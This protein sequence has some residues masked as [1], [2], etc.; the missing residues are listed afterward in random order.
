MGSI[1]FT[2]AASKRVDIDGRVELPGMIGN[3]P[4]SKR[5]T[6]ER[7]RDIVMRLWNILEHSDLQA[8][9]LRSELLS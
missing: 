8:V 9:N 2:P 1:D 3:E 7:F 5:N 4:E 6:V